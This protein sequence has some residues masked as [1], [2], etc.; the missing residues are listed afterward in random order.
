MRAKRE[1]ARKAEIVIWKKRKKESKE[2]RV[3]EGFLGSL[4]QAET[5]AKR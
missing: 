5:N 1:G 4:V 3:K 2:H